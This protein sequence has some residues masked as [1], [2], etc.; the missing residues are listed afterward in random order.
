MS[1]KITFRHIV[2]FVTGVLLLLLCFP[3]FAQND[4][5]SPFELRINSGGEATTFGLDTFEADAYFVGDGK[6]FTNPKINNIDATDRDALY[7]SERSTTA[8]LG[9]F[10]YAVPLENGTY[11]IHLHFAEIW[12]GATGGGA[13]G[14]GKRVFDAT[15]EGQRILANFDIHA[16]VGTMTSVVKTYVV[17]VDDGMLDL[18][19]AASVNQPKLSAFEI[20]GQIPSPSPADFI[21][22]INCGGEELTLKGTVFEADAFFKG[23]LRVYSNPRIQDVSNTTDDAL[24]LTERTTSADTG[25]FEYAI[26][27]ENGSYEVKLHFAEIYWGATGGGA[28]GPNKRVF[29]VEMEGNEI[30]VAFDINAEVGSMTAMI[31][32][33]TT[34]ITDGILNLRFSSTV[35]R[36]TI[37]AIEI[38]GEEQNDMDELPLLT[39]INAGGDQETFEGVTFY[40]DR[41]AEGNG[42]AYANNAITTIQN[43]DFDAIYKSERSTINDSGTFSYRIPVTDGAYTVKLHFAEIYWGATNGGANGTGKR[44]FDV[45]LEDESILSDYDINAEV[46]TMTAT[47]KV[48]DTRVTDGELTLDFS[49]SVNQ[50]K[51]AAIEVFGDGKI[52]EDATP[53]SFTDLADSSLRRLESQSADVKGKIYVFAGFLP[54]LKITAKTE[55]YDPVSNSWALGAPMPTP[56][57]HMGLAVVNDEVWIL[58]GF[59]GNH[60]GV[61]T[62]KVQIYNTQSNTWREGPA[63]PNRRGSGAASFYNG[64]IH[65]FGGLMPDRKT[66]VGEHFVFDPNNPNL[67]WQALA[68][69][70]NPRNHL[71]AATVDGLIYAIGGQYGH[72]AGVNDQ[73]FLHAFDPMTNA[74]VR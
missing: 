46:G 43:T 67:G 55:I 35:N 42:K 15:L 9:S 52:L 51:V 45:V 32:S 59:I 17:T 29:N 16:E 31:K 10:G 7:L 27:L 50:P 71:S 65:F 23:D 63:L 33:F 11:T 70:P 13:G 19:L 72:D 56:V 1:N 2:Q 64:K 21:K 69:L 18:S 5:H 57:T 74:W 58:A 20:I 73:K 62:E 47:I 26:P 6:S 54:G 41:Y 48:F 36:P 12:W 28:N 44:V 25:A 8:N 37:A 22:R 49:A 39:R 61:A 53:C 66:D 40:A 60:P 68:P 38:S 4:T 30:L 3:L 34:T 14:N 24:Y